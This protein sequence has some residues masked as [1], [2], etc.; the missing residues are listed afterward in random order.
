MA[1]FP[2]AVVSR[3]AFP[4]HF[5]QTY[6][7]LI[8]RHDMYSGAGNAKSQNQAGIFQNQRNST[9]RNRRDQSA[10]SMFRLPL[11][12]RSGAFQDPQDKQ[13]YSF[14]M[15]YDRH[16]FR[17]RRERLMA[18]CVRPKQAH[19]N[20]GTSTKPCGSRHCFHTDC[21]GDARLPWHVRNVTSRQVERFFI[22]IWSGAEVYLL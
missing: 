1:F 20:A 9:G 3:A 16:I 13:I 18:F 15:S 4:L 6:V 21:L 22:S 11:V 12:M 5:R 19:G 8:R 2:C 14:F 7:L 10:S 17:L